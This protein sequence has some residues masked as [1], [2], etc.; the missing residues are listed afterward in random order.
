MYEGQACPVTVSYYRMPSWH[1]GTV[2]LDPATVSSLKV[3]AGQDGLFGS[4]TLQQYS[5]IVIDFARGEL[6]LGPFHPT[7]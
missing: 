4:G 1:L 3:P 5:P 7:R 2:T 6:L